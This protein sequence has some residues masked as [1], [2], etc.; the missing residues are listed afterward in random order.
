[1]HLSSRPP[2]YSTASNPHI[3]SSRRSRRGEPASAYQVQGKVLLYSREA[4]SE[5]EL[6]GVLGDHGSVRVEGAEIKAQGYE[7]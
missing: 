3:L 6:C 5:N 1:M 4:G 2:L 7:F